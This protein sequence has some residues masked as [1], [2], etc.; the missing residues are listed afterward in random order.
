MNRRTASSRRRAS[1]R[2]LGVEYV[3]TFRPEPEGGYTVRCEAFPEIVTYGRTLE[4]ARY[5]A[6]E[7]IALCIAVYREDG[8]RIPR[9]A[10]KLRSVIQER[11]S[12]AGVLT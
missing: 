9:P 3:C 6:R 5:N 1:V 10:P 4:E 8:R 7:A 12:I 11:V 2:A